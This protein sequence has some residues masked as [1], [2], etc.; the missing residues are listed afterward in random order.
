MRKERCHLAP[1]DQKTKRRA[2]AS[3]A[4]SSPVIYRILK[5]SLVQKKQSRCLGWYQQ[6]LFQKEP[7][8]EKNCSESPGSC[9]A[10]L[11]AGLHSGRHTAV[12]SRCGQV[13][14]SHQPRG[15]N[16]CLQRRQ[17]EIAKEERRE[18]VKQQG[19]WLPT[20]RPLTSNYSCLRL[21][22][23]GLTLVQPTPR[24]LLGSPPASHP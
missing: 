4:F 13:S 2:V 16:F 19:S 24:S 9:H 15:S 10:A 18:G 5:N 12:K 8:K 11:E 1:W 20:R 17:R 22:R 3:L 14:T 6:G 7:D 23:A 21:P